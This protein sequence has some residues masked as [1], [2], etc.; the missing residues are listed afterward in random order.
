MKVVMHRETLR[1]KWL[2]VL[3][4]EDDG[5]FPAPDVNGQKYVKR[6]LDEYLES[7][8]P[9]L[10]EVRVVN[11]PMSLVDYHRAADEHGPHGYDHYYQRT[12]VLGTPN[13]AQVK[14]HQQIATMLTEAQGKELPDGVIP[15]SLPA[16]GKK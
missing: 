7:M 15:D 16:K 8:G 14:L 1:S 3:H 12:S 13:D 6:H 2:P 5:T 9:Y 4:T 10:G 11:H